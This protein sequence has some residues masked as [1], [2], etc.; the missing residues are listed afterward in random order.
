MVSSD[1]PSAGGAPTEATPAHDAPA[2]DAPAEDARVEDAPAE[3]V[4]AVAHIAVPMEQRAVVDERLCWS[5]VAGL[6][7]IHLAAVVGIV[8]IVLNPSA[9]TILLAASLYVVCGMSIT[10]GYHRLSA[11]RT[12]RAS[13]PVR[14]GMLAFGA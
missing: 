9:A 2:H 7:V 12:Y 10:A 4:R 6:S 14:W 13:M 11:H 8:W 1:Q 5:T 3:D